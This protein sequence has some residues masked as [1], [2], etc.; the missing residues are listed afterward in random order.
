MAELT[1]EARA[2]IKLVRDTIEALDPS[3]F[4]MSQWNTAFVISEKIGGLVHE[5]GSCGCIGGWTE[6]LF[7]SD[8]VELPSEEE[9][10]GLLG[11]DYDEGSDL[12]YPPRE[13]IPE[14]VDSEWKNILPRHAVQVLDHLLETG[15]VDWSIITE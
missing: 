5:C 8:R 9:T 7:L 6:A 15:K 14:W 11:L 10:R 3:R 13:Q 2:N 1:D 12:F 4:D